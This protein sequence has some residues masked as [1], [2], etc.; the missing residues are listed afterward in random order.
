MR[1]FYKS[2]KKNKDNPRDNDQEI[3]ARPSSRRYSSILYIIWNVAVFHQ[4]S[5]MQNKTTIRYNYPSTKMTEKTYYRNHPY[6]LTR[7]SFTT[8]GKK[9]AT[10]ILKNW[11]AHVI[12]QN[13]GISCLR[14]WR[15][16]SVGG[17]CQGKERLVWDQSGEHTEAKLSR[18]L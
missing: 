12:T 3:W 11:S 1:N 18:A 6:M 17:A 16:A 8:T 2:I 4:S 9:I 14:N 7:I 15:E 13:K 5:A 10:N